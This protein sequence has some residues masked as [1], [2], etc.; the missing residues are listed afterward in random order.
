MI[1][2]K[3][4]EEIKQRIF[5]L[6]YSI[7]SLGTII[8]K[9]SD[10]LIPQTSLGS[11]NLKPPELGFIR[12]VAW[13]YALYFE[14]GKENIKFLSK[15]FSVYQ[16]DREERAA[17]HK[18]S[19]NYLRTSLQHDLFADTSHNQEIQSLCKVWYN[20]CC[21]QD[22]PE[23]DIQWEKCLQSIL[24]EAEFF[25]DSLDCCVN[26]ISQEKEYFDV[27]VT[28]WKSMLSH[29]HP[30]YEFDRIIESVA[31][32]LGRK[33]L[34]PVKFREKNYSAWINELQLLKEY[35][36]NTDVRKIIE[37]DL[38][39]NVKPVLPINGKDIM[40]YFGIPPGRQVGELLKLGYSLFEIQPSESNELLKSIHDE[41][42]KKGL[43]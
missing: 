32:D 2:N 19:I 18:Q 36:F 14:A 39:K 43:L 8:L 37:R 5:S 25:F 40:D 6:I 23:K 38:I 17:K 33:N 27:I 24:E 34:D 42:I 4:E 3:K 26:K 16:I 10:P 22:Y 31:A 12:T 35:D 30:P 20:D 13:L 11:F 28:E 21:S 41:A 1:K 15:K 29:Y 7:N 9:N